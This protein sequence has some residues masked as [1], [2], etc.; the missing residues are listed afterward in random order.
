MHETDQ[1]PTTPAAA[2]QPRATRR[3][4]LALTPLAAVAPGATLG[5]LNADKELIACCGEVIELERHVWNT[6]P[7]RFAAGE[8]LALEAAQAPYAA[9]S[10]RIMERIVAAK[11]HTLPGIAAKAR[12]LSAIVPSSVEDGE[13]WAA[14]DQRALSSILRDL[15]AAVAA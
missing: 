5:Q 4:I 12:A 1:T 14:L 7:A 10:V 15:L 11:A 8:D 2:R 6:L 3:S 13:G 9:R